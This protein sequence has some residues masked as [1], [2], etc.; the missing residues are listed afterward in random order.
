LAVIQAAACDVTSGETCNMRLLDAPFRRKLPV[1]QDEQDA[2]ADTE[3]AYYRH[4]LNT[5]KRLP[6]LTKKHCDF[7]NIYT[8]KTDTIQKRPKIRDGQNHN[9]NIDS[10]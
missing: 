5:V 3:N 10:I 7:S 2:D 9:C 6:I 1:N 4:P 8:S